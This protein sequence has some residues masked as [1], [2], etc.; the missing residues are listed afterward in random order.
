MKTSVCQSCGFVFTPKNAGTT[1]EQI[2]SEEYCEGCMKNGKFT[3]PSLSIHTLELK[4][5]E[6][7]KTGEITLEEHTHLINILPNLKR[8]QM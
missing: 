3:N 4:L 7:A 6:M 8:W 1:V 2:E 5:N